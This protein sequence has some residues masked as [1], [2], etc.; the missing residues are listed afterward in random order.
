MPRQNPQ[1]TLRTTTAL[2]FAFTFPPARPF[3]RLLFLQKEDSNFVKRT[4]EL[5]SCRLNARLAGAA[6]HLAPALD[7]LRAIAEQAGKF[8]GR[9]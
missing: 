9:K 2:V 7:G 3:L 6:L 8:F 4:T 5:L 1:A